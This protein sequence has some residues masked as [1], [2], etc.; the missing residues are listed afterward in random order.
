[1]KGNPASELENEME[2]FDDF[3]IG[4]FIDA[5]HNLTK[6]VLLFPINFQIVF[7]TLG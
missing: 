7:L 4:D 2:A 5:Y 3:I 6:K 1:M